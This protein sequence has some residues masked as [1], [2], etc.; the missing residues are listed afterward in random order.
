MVA[1]AKEVIKRSQPSYYILDELQDTDVGQFQLLAHLSKFGAAPNESRLTAVGDYDQAI[2]GFRGAFPEALRDQMSRLFPNTAPVRLE[3]NYRST[4]AIVA[5]CRAIV[6]PNYV[7]SAETPKDLKAHR[8]TGLPVQLVECGSMDA[9]Y[10]RIAEE[11]DAWCACGVAIG[12]KAPGKGD[13]MAVLF[14]RKADVEF[15]ADFMR[16][17]WVHDPLK[18][19]VTCRDDSGDSSASSSQG[20]RDAPGDALYVSTIHA[21]KGTEYEIVFLAGLG[22][23]KG[24]FRQTWVG[25]LKWSVKCSAPV[26][27][28]AVVQEN[29]RVQFV[30]AS[31]PRSLLH[32]SYAGAADGWCEAVANLKAALG[33]QRSLLE[34]PCC[35]NA[36][37][38]KLLAAAFAPQRTCAALMGAEA[39]ARAEERLAPGAEEREE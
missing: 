16:T 30:G 34:Q 27:Q 31:R 37:D 35:R 18:K 8:A 2:Y 5:A 26:G 9:E 6:A 17:R 4:P 28:A 38:A 32:V 19:V 14:L 29:R 7:G 13:G 23:I 36:A 22:E 3:N 20:E 15:F 21:A 33:R 25:S 10:Q 1:A 39:A 12:I 11:I 24:D